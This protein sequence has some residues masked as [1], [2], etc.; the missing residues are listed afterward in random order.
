SGDRIPDAAVSA[1][2]DALARRFARAGVDVTRLRRRIRAHVAYSRNGSHTDGVMHRSDAS[3]GVFRRAAELADGPV[4]ASGLL[5]ALLE[6]PDPPWQ[7]AAADLGAV[8]RLR[9]LLQDLESDS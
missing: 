5:R 8:D 9:S 2:S 6:L 1:E 4:G 7:P 3:R